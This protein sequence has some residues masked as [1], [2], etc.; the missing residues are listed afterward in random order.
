MKKL[1]DISLSI[2]NALY[3][4][5]KNGGLSPRNSPRSPRSSPLSPRNSPRSPRN[6]EN[7]D[8][9]VENISIPPIYAQK[10]MQF[11]V[12]WLNEH[13]LKV[14]KE[15]ATLFILIIYNLFM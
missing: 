15:L 12:S 1:Q 14:D 13:V 6:I 5:N 3:I 8:S 9:N 11:M 10:L 4:G 7:L 2:L